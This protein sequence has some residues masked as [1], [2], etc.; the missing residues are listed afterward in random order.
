MA[1]RLTEINAEIA[2][3]D[4]L[5][6][7]LAERL[8]RGAMSLAAFDRANEPLAKA[9]ARLHA[10]RE[11]LDGG[12][13]TGPASAQ[14]A[15]AVAAQWD[16]GTNAERRAMLTQALGASTMYLDRYV[17]R[18]G[19]RSFDRNRLRLVDSQNEGQ[20]IDK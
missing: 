16:A 12:A 8:G 6:I 14:S 5:Q 15:T 11:T 7:A 2:D 9:L 4:G 18:P 3:G 10:E 20:F 17:Q 19:P 1:D 13:P